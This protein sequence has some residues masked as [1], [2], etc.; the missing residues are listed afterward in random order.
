MSDNEM[1]DDKAPDEEGVHTEQSTTAH[2]IA[3]SVESWCA[4]YNVILTATCLQ[5]FLKKTKEIRLVVG[6][7]EGKD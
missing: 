4:G 5:D 3:T 2:V 6:K 1:K 7:D